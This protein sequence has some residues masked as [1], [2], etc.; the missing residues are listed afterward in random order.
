MPLILSVNRAL[1]TSSTCAFCSQMLLPGPASP[2]WRTTSLIKVGNEAE[3]GAIPARCCFLLVKEQ[4]PVHPSLT[5]LTPNIRIFCVLC[6]CGREQPQ[7]SDFEFLVLRKGFF[8]ESLE[9]SESLTLCV[10][11][12]LPSLCFSLPWHSSVT[13]GAT[14]A[15]PSPPR[16]ALT[17][18]VPQDK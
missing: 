8:L 12:S 6:P 1:T 16:A 2:W 4:F 9:L 15:S 14:R 7:P 17:E 11:T 10:L 5:L 13:H 18:W 3:P